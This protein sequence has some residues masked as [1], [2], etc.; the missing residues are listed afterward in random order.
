MIRVNLAGTPKRKSGK[1]A[2]KSAGPSNFLPVIH[3]LIMVGAT[4]GGYLW[5]S[6]LT[7]K[8]TDLAQQIATREADMKRL[9]AVIKQNAIYEARKGDLDRRIRIID[10]LK[11]SQVSPVVMLDRLVDSVDRTRFVWISTFTQNNSTISMVGT[12]T[13]LE[14]LAGFYSNLQDT[15]YFHNINVNR[16]EDSRAGNVAF[17]LTSDFAPPAS[18]KPAAK[19]AN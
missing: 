6:Q 9:D 12:A 1:A 16:F 14:A 19:G 8:S 4:V 7:T 11:K 13:N 15:G 18:P 2:A 10:D 5:Y 17:T 3:L